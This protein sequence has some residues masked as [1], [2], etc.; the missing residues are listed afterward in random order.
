MVSIEDIKLPPH[1]VDAEKWVLAWILMENDLFFVYDG[2]QLMP[3]DFYKKEHQQI[4][5]GM[6]Q[7][8]MQ[9]RTIDVVTLS[10]Q[11]V[12][13]DQ[14]DYVG[15]QDYLFELSTF[16]LTTSSCGE[17]A[18]L[19]KEKS[20]LRGILKTCQ[21]ITGD[22]YEQKDTAEILDKVEKRVF[23]LTQINLA[24][25]LRHVKDVLSQRIDHYMEIIDNPELGDK[26]KVMSTYHK[27]DEMLWWF[28]PGEL[29]IL[30]ARP[31]MGKTALALNL[32]LNAAIEQKKSVAFFSLEM[33]SESLVDRILSTVSRIPLYKI[34]K[35]KLEAD[36]FTS[37]GEAIEQLW[38]ANIYLDDQGIATVPQMK[39]KLRRLKIEKWSLDLVIIDY[40]QL[41]SGAGGKYEWNRVQ[42]VSQIS[43][44]LK[45]LSKELN[46][47]IMALSQLSRNVESRIDKQPQLADL[48]ESGSIEQDADAVLMLYREDYYD[49]DTDRKG[50]TDLLVRKNRNGQVW[51]IELMFRAETMKFEEVLDG[52][53]DG[54]W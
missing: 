45:E 38:E 54:S 32:V 16:L 44:G 24:D 25:S 48:R 7:L 34:T 28:K 31:A 14:L 53:W 46:V 42:E 13:M 5:D 39:S 10:D 3:Q 50:A 33:T 12:K 36:D 26:H 8:R 18:Q 15:G 40:L 17:Y 27:L 6:K 20:V 9:R 30:A 37:M 49:P 21:H 47:P 22:V 52:E 29:L 43:R 23:D 1:S 2:F 4:F 11:L 35:N 19:V 51:S 41:M